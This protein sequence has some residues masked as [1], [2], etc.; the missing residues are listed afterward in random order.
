[1][2][3][4]ASLYPTKSPNCHNVTSLDLI[5]QDGHSLCYHILKNEIIIVLAQ[6]CFPHNIKVPL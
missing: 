4:G 2:C 5:F 3:S 6:K 1:M